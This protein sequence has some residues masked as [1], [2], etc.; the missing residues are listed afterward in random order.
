MENC[1]DFYEKFFDVEES[2]RCFDELMKISLTSKHKVVNEDK[3]IEIPRKIGYFSNLGED[4]AYANLVLKG[5]VWE[6][7]LLKI[8]AELEGR[9]NCEFNSVLVNLYRDGNDTIDWHSDAEK[10]LGENP[11][12][13]SVNFGASRLFKFKEKKKGEKAKFEYLLEHGTVIVM[14]NECQT[15][16]LHSIRRDHTVVKPRFNLTYRKVNY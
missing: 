15:K 12:I 3:E 5:Q 7:V 6:P 13:A 16:Y 2:D 10:Q 11:T 8:K 1:L 14:K 4:Y 9:L